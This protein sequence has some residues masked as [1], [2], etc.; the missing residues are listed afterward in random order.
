MTDTYRALCEELAAEWADAM[1]RLRAALAQPEPQ[2]LNHEAAARHTVESCLSQ[3]EEVLAAFIA[4]HGFCP[5]E[6]IQIEQR[7]EDGSTTWR[8]ERRAELV[9]PE[10]EEPTIPSR[11]S[12][13]EIAVYRDGFHAGFKEA[14]DRAFYAGYKEALARAALAEQPENDPSQISDGFHT[15]AEL[16]EHRHA[17]TLSLMKAKPEMFWFSRRHNDG[18]LCFGVGDWFIVGAEL[19]T[20]GSISYHLPMALWE[21]AQRSGATML[22]IGRPWDG[23]TPEDVVER[24]KAWAALAKQ[25]VAPTD[26]QIDELWDKEAGYYELYEEVRNVVRA[27]LAQPERQRLFDREVKQL[28]CPP[29]AWLDPL[30]DQ[31]SRALLAQPPADGEVRELVNDLQNQANHGYSE[32]ISSDDL[33]RAAELLEQRHPTP[34]PVAERL[35]GPEDLDP[36]GRCWVYQNEKSTTHWLPANALPVPTND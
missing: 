17:L 25:P 14:L 32:F 19:P 2:E 10:A 26:D 27:V 15:F 28:C 1:R 12:G 4:K 33:R 21:S 8:I 20:V 24:L 7:Q 11:Y 5:D 16:Y 3:R 31:R 13:Y 36:N 35:P 9:E 30:T 23:H 29:R 34:I 22:K 18:E 6:A